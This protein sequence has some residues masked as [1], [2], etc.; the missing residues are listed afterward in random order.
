MKKNIISAMNILF[1][2]ILVIVILFTLFVL[3]FVNPALGKFEKNVVG[4]PEPEPEP[5]ITTD[6]AWK[7]V[8]NLNKDFI[9][10]STPTYW[11]ENENQFWI[12][13][14]INSY[15]GGGLYG[16]TI[17]Y[18]TLE[19]PILKLQEYYGDIDYL[20]YEGDGNIK[21]SLTTE[22]ENPTL[23]V[24]DCNF[25]VA[26]KEQTY[27]LNV[28]YKSSTVEPEPATEMKVTF[29]CKN[30]SDENPQNYMIFIYQNDNIICQVIPTVAESSVTLT[31]DENY[32][33]TNGYEIC[34][35]FGYFGSISFE[36][37]SALEVTAPRKIKVSEFADV[38]IEYEISTPKINSTL[39][40]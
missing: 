6:Y 11:D 18:D 23:T 27:V 15:Y 22:G 37:N 17:F 29:N 10:G 38:L 39:I 16:K 36:S 32:D 30:Y 35:V 28:V 24:D 25:V 33:S 12:K 13:V 21:Y 26:E 40:I 4:M 14:R 19:L 8:I 5:V 34:F 9:T 20:S 2:T 7:V 3:G 1:T 31:K